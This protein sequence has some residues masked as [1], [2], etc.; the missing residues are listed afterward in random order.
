M[1]F[2]YKSSNWW[3]LAMLL[4]LLLS[5]LAFRIGYIYYQNHDLQ[6]RFAVKADDSSYQLGIPM[7]EMDL[8]EFDHLF[9]IIIAPLKYDLT[10]YIK[11]PVALRYYNEIP[12]KDTD[13]ALEISKGTSITAIPLETQGL[14]IHEAGYGY[15]SYPT[16]TKGWR[17]VK[18]F[19]TEAGEDAKQDQFYYIRIE[20][21][22]VVLGETIDANQPLIA[23]ARRQSWLGYKAS[24]TM[25]RYIDHTL[26]D[27]GIY[28]SYDLS[29]RIW[30]R[31]NI[32]LA[33]LT[34]ILAA[35]LL[36]Q[37]MRPGL[38]TNRTN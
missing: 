28:Q 7:D 8:S 15:T 22:E 29:H 37:A 18:P 3:Y 9:S 21:L 17:Y 30:D 27:N 13:Y 19:R 1:I 11:T 12:E 23:A 4:I 2:S 35:I 33:S 20:S 34:A 24:H 38:M 36:S 25:V 5:I 14:N 16:Y 10:H 32:V 6:E 26:Y 31:I